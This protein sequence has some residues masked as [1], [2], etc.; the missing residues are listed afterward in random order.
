[1]IN[2]LKLVLTL[3]VSLIVKTVVKTITVA[4]NIA[5]LPL[6]ILMSL[7]APT[8]IA[9]LMIEVIDER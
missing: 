3:V 2:Y 6:L 4:V 7:L 9:R 1:M 8:F 5:A